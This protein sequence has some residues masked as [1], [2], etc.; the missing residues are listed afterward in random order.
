M[1]E[2]LANAFPIWV[3]VACGLALIEPAL[4]SWFQGKLIVGGLAVIM[5]GMGLTLRWADFVAVV[6]VPRFVMIGV[7][8]QFSIMPLAGWGIATL[9]GLE[10]GLAIGLILVACCPG[11]T[12]SNV[13]C[14]LAK[15]NVPL[16]VLNI[17]GSYM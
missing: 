1:L 17:S 2:R 6:R 7:L 3:A 11:G 14:Y 16:R 12:A 9:F 15:A 13:I 8:A 5:L 10:A 4:F